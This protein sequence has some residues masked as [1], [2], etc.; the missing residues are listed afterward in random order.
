MQD[1]R[2]EDT[3]YGSGNGLLGAT[4]ATPMKPSCLGAWDPAL[5]QANFLLVCRPSRI[6]T[7]IWRLLLPKHMLV[8]FQCK[9]RLRST[10]ADRRHQPLWNGCQQGSATP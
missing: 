1:M 6:R 10:L 9:H 5:L 8:K 7:L 4:R 3:G 2:W